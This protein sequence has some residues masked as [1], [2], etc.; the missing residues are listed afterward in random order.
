MGPYQFSHGPGRRGPSR[1]RSKVPNQDSP[2][3]HLL[4]DCNFIPRRLDPLSV[5]HGRLDGDF[6]AILL[7]TERLRS[8]GSNAHVGI[9]SASRLV[10]PRPHCDRNAV[11]GY[12]STA[13][14]IQIY[15]GPGERLRPAWVVLS[16]PSLFEIADSRARHLDGLLYCGALAHARSDRSSDSDEP[17]G[18]RLRRHC[19]P[20]VRNSYHLL[21]DLREGR[22][23]RRWQERV[24]APGLEQTRSLH[25][26]CLHLLDHYSHVL[27][28]WMAHYRQ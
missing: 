26:A 18:P 14:I 22:A 2:A 21:P 17:A 25:R 3:S 15:M 20:S 8:T 27:S 19:Y 24:D 1:R 4:V 10:H 12:R 28:E 6:S 7:S 16:P 11:P 13:C 5:P 23:R 9:T